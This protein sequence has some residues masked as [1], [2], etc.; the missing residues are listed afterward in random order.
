VSDGRKTIDRGDLKGTTYEF[1]ILAMSI[2]S[3]VN[4][5]LMALTL[6]FAIDFYNRLETSSARRHYFVRGGGILDLLS[7]VPGFRSPEPRRG[8]TVHLG[9]TG[10]APALR[11]GWSVV[12]SSR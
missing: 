4:L 8:G 2:L 9:V 6:V 5:A 10:G 11:E 12:E 3:I 1:F 7:C